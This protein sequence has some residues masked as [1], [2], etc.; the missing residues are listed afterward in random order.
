MTS[1]VSDLAPHSRWRVRENITQLATSHDEATKAISELHTAADIHRD[2][3]RATGPGRAR[4]WP[5][6][7]M[8][9]D[10]PR[11]IW[12]GLV[13]LALTLLL[14]WISARLVTHLVPAPIFAAILPGILLAAAAGGAARFATYSIKQR[15]GAGAAGILPAP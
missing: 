15:D 6:M 1:P 2:R 10:W 11:V 9:L 14:G 8:R 4:L 13:L 3:I 7:A 12:F 5:R